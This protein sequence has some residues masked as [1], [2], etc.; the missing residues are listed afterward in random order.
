MGKKMEKYFIALVPEGRVRELAEDVKAALNER[1]GVKYALKSPAHVTVKMPFLWKESKEDEL[2]RILSRFAANQ[3]P[4]PLLLKGFGHFRQRVIYIHIW[5]QRRLEELQAALQEL[6]KGKLKLDLE[7]SDQS[8]RPH[9]TVAYNDLK[10]R[11]FQ[12]CF[13]FVRDLGFDQRVQIEDVALLKKRH[14]KWEVLTRFPLGGL[15]V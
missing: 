9:M 4:F 11:D 15:E 7:L 3:E 6:A 13:D 14:G 8:F 10:K 1:F 2:K 5:P 12:A